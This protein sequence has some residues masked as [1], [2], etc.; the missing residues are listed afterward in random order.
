MI[1]IPPRVVNQYAVHKLHPYLKKYSEAIPNFYQF[2]NSVC[3]Y[4]LKEDD[5]WNF[6]KKKWWSL[7]EKK[8]KSLSK[9]HLVNSNLSHSKVCFRT[10]GKILPVNKPLI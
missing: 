5:E 4:N 10:F 9:G 7:T 2:I 1:T 3:E 6:V 8:N